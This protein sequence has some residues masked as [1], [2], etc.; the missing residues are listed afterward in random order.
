MDRPHVLRHHARERGFTL[1]EVIVVL[2][3]LAVLAAILLL[4]MGSAKDTGREK[5]SLARMQE[6]K[7]VL[8]RARDRQQMQLREIVGAGSAGACASV[9][10]MP[11]VAQLGGAC[12]TAWNTVNTKLAP[13][14]GSAEAAAALMTD[15]TG[16]PILVDARETGCPATGTDQLTAVHPSGARG[17]PSQTLALDPS[18]Y[19]C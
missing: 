14:V 15:S 11:T 16:R 9:N 8:Q 10:P 1:I 7:T 2:G 5:A 12:R 6:A 17:K 13:Y 18:S 4:T 3:I 19:G